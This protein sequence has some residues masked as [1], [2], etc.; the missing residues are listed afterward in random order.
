[1]RFKGNPQLLLVMVLILGVA[2]FFSIYK[3]SQQIDLV[4][5]AE[6]TA[7]FGSTDVSLPSPPSSPIITPLPQVA[8]AH[9]E[10]VVVKRVIDGDTIELNDGRK[11]RYIG[12]D[13]PETKAPNKAVECYGQAAY[14]F[15]QQLVE[16]L[17]I[18]LEQD[19]SDTDR[20]GRL[21]RYVYKDD[22]LVNLL[23]VKQGYAVASSYP[24][25]IAKQEQFR[26]AESEARQ[27]GAGL[28]SSCSTTP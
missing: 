17:E 11:V 20:Y 28:W 3:G 5:P 22:Q 27:A 19:V 26:Q 18:R 4:L 16:G 6:V 21:L 23:L 14:I 24:P 7:L 25:D 9:G 1:M 13:T 2:S 10:L 15:N 8:A 12:I